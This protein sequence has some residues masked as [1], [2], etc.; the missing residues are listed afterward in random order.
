MRHGLLGHVRPMIQYSCVSPSQCPILPQ[1]AHFVFFSGG[2]RGDLSI[3][4]R[5]QQVLLILWAF[6][7]VAGTRVLAE[8][9]CFFWFG[10][11]AR[12]K[13]SD[14]SGIASSSF[15]KVSGSA[16]SSSSELSS[17]SNSKSGS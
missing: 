10:T 14:T 8:N 9:P 1:A 7:V 15:G 17:C 3:V 12:W 5:Q 4:S 2:P 16:G 6:T 13:G 11:P